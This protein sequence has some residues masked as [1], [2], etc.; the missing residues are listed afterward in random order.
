MNMLKM[1][2]TTAKEAIEAAGLNWTVS[3]RDLFFRGMDEMKGYEDS[4]AIVRDDTDEVLGIVGSRYN[5]IQNANAFEL[6]DEFV[7]SGEAKYKSAHSYKGGKVVSMDLSLTRENM[8]TVRVGDDIETVIKVVT[9]HDGSEKF[10]A[11]LLMNRLICSN[12]MVRPNTCFAFNVKHTASAG[13]RIA[14]GMELLNVARV[15]GAEMAENARKMANTYFTMNA[16]R[17]YV[18]RV[19]GIKKDD[20][21]ATKTENKREAIISLAVR[22]LGNNGST[23]WDAYNGVTEY[24][25]HHINTRGDN[26]RLTSSVLGSGLQLK[27][28]A[29]TIAQEFVHA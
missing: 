12:G 7:D 16:T 11:R 22:G 25:D 26:D 29:Y 19:L 8:H 21:L 27:E 24:A 5:V 6:L 15:F 9:S 13:D 10:S 14:N 20:E 2:I 1:N 4:K 3:K 28:R 17:E 23:L 18:N